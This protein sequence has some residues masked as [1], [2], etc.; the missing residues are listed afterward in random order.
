[1]F[2][3]YLVG[4][5]IANLSNFNYATQVWFTKIPELQKVTYYFDL[6]YYF[7]FIFTYYQ[8]KATAHTITNFRF[9]KVYN[10]YFMQRTVIFE[11]CF[12][13]H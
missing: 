4:H 12:P 2:I 7:I 13:I 10:Y 1:M 8:F 5:I 6:T 3:E 11:S 9:A